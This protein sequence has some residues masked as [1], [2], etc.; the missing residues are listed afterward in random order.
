MQMEI[1]LPKALRIATLTQ[2]EGATK[3][4][5]TYV[6][7]S[8]TANSVNHVNLKLD[9]LKLF[10]EAVTSSDDT[11]S[12]YSKQFKMPKGTDT[13]KMA[14]RIDEAKHALIVEAP[15]KI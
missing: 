8:P 5:I 2:K 6:D 15:F 14:Y 12:T 13:D 10:L 3:K 11:T 4:S 9:G 7:A 1:S